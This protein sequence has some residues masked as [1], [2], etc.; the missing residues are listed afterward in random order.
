MSVLL[1]GLLI[2]YIGILLYSVIIHE[3]AHAITADYL[4]DPTARQLGRITFRPL[5]HLDFFGSFLVPFGLLLISGGKFAF[6]WAKPVPFNLYNLRDQRWGPAWVALAGPMSN[7]LLALTG[8]IVGRLLPISANVKN[9][10]V[11]SALSGNWATLFN[12]MEGNIFAGLF[13]IIGIAVLLNLILAGFNLI[14]IP[15]LDGS[16]LLLALNLVSR[17]AYAMLEQ[18]GFLIL[19]LV[20]F[21]GLL[22]FVFLGLFQ[23]AMLLLGV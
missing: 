2:V 12:T 20:I 17:Q 15:P 16:K 8:G 5:P 7:I 10:L 14:P 13:L 21:S 1:I 9:T 6:G 19:I 11:S 22:D 23:V 4:G 18:Y 3:M